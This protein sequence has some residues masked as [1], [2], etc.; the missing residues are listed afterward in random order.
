MFSS[1]TIQKV[2]KKAP[3]SFCQSDIAVDHQCCAV[4]IENSPQLS[5]IIGAH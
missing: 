3:T 1:L 2:K 4:P 5:D